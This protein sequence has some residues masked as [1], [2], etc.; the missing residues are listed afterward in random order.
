VGLSSVRDRI[1][2]TFSRLQSGTRSPI[3]IGRSPSN[4]SRKDR[5]LAAPPQCRLRRSATP[6]AQPRLRR[7]SLAASNTVGSE[8]GTEAPPGGLADDQGQGSEPPDIARSL[9]TPPPTKVSTNCDRTTSEMRDLS[10]KITSGDS[11]RSGNAQTHTHKHTVPNI[12]FKLKLLQVKCHVL[13]FTADKAQNVLQKI[14]RVFAEAFVSHDRHSLFTLEESG[15][16]R[17]T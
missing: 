4:C 17:M 10:P 16:P 3:K 6:R 11:R 7:A 2:R 8:E 12:K 9:C 15:P 1:A 14:I 5:A 13:G